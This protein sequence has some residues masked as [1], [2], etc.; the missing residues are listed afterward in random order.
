MMAQVDEME[1]TIKET[2]EFVDKLKV[3]LDQANA[4]K[5]VLEN[6]AKTTKDQVAMLQL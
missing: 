1:R 3:D 4:S 2:L 6:R 5:L